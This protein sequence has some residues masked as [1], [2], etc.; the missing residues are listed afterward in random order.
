MIRSLAA[1]LTLMLATLALAP[2]AERPENQAATA[3]SAAVDTARTK[4]ASGDTAGAIAGLEAYVPGHPADAGA[5]RLLGD[6]YFRIPDYRRAEATWQALVTRDP[7]DK[8]THNRLGSLYAAEDRISDSIAEFE[9]SLPTRSGFY[10]LVDAHRRAGDLAAFEQQIAAIALSHPFD[11]V[12]LSSYANVLRA[13][14]K[15]VQAQPYFARVVTL[16]G[17]TCGAL[18]DVG[19]N[20]IDL[21]RLDEAIANLGR[22][23]KIEPQNYP[24]LVDIGEANIERNEL[25]VSR[26]YLDRAIAAKSDG[27]EALV[28]IGYILDLNGD[29][30]NAIA[31]YLRAMNADPLQAAAYI[32]LGFDYNDHQLYKLAE[33]AFLKG[34]SVEPDDG[35]LHYMLAVTYNIQGKVQLARD[36]YERAIASQEPIVVRAARAELALLP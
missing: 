4:V 3:P 9:K 12:S 16:T 5:A 2:P 28:D 34:L 32:D 8:E 29:W 36:Q 26:S 15:F 13:Q 17:G 20:E 18:V 19:N 23:L 30:K 1:A 25:T 27:S 31:Y 22:C 35:R 10:G 24:A 6:L 7:D 11:P 21:G 33:A 14:R